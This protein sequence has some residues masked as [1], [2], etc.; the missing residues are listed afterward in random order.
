MRKFFAI[1]LF[2]LT[3]TAAGVVLSFRFN[4]WVTTRQYNRGYT[5][6]WKDG[7]N[8][9]KPWAD[10]QK[11]VGAEPDGKWGPESKAAYDTALINQYNLWGF[12][13]EIWK[14]D[15]KMLAGVEK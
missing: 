13:P 9:I 8:H 5:Q 7:Y 11:Q 10:L 12:N 1:L 14:F 3:F 6:G 2:T 15:K 4:G